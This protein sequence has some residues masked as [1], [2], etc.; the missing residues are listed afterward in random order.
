VTVYIYNSKGS[1]LSLLQSC[2]ELKVTSHFR[3]ET[4]ASQALGVD[5]GLCYDCRK[6]WG[7]IMHF[8]IRVGSVCESVMK[9]LIFSPKIRTVRVNF[10]LVRVD[11]EIPFYWRKKNL[12]DLICVKNSQISNNILRQRRT[13]DHV[14]KNSARYIHYIPYIFWCGIWLLLLVPTILMV[15]KVFPSSH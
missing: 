11:V 5:W 14:F 12:R 4:P 15:S 10:T 9:F 6:S 1:S 8:W 13:I 2:S 3:L 7:T